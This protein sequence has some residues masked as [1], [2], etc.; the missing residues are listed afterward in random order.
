LV[1]K[2]LKFFA[3]L[4][5]T[6]YIIILMVQQNFDGPTFLFKSIFF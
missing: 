4:S 5:L 1:A 3:S 2:M 6:L